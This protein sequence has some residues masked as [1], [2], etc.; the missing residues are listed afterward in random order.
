MMARGRPPKPREVRLADGNPG[1]RPLPAPVLG[2]GKVLEFPAP[3]S[4]SEREREVWDQLVPEVA[5]LG[6]I[7]R[8]DRAMLELLVQQVA[9]VE[10]ARDSIR[11]DGFMLTVYDRDGNPL[12]RKVNPAA[13]LQIQATAQALRLAEQ[14]GLTSS[15]RARLGLTVAKGAAIASDLERALGGDDDADVVIEV[16]E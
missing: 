14:F 8:V 16:P 11:S 5:A 15:A 3:A 1:H 4:L 13:R 6:W 7:D 9:L 12:D 10:L 2:L